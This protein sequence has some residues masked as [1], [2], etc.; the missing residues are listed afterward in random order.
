[1]QL[2]ITSAH[3]FQINASK[4]GV[5]KHGLVEAHLAELGV[6]EDAHHNTKVHG[7]PDRGLC[8]YSLEKILALQGERHPI[9]PGAIGENLT[10]VG[11]DWERLEPGARLRV[12]DQVLIEIT[13]YT[14]PC[15]KIVPYFLNGDVE[16]VSQQQHPGWSRLYAKVINPGLVRV[17]DRVEFVPAK[18]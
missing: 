13:G 18:N 8:L 5:P 9:F 12:G 1:M 14:R 4:G 2:D 17:G 16:R 15:R 11:L 3:I 7:G 6:E 10:I